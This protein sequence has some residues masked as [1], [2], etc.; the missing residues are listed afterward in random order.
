MAS[1]RV[2]LRASPRRL[3]NDRAFRNPTALLCLRVIVY[4]GQACTVSFKGT[5]GIR[6]GVEVEAESLYEV[7]VEAIARFRQDPWMEQVGNATIDI[8]IGESATTHAVT[9]KQVES[10]LASTSPSPHIASKKIRLK[11]M[12][13][14]G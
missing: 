6:H 4:D 12:L 2:A 5:S 7:A 11:M 14:N 3:P 8:E 13:M 9:L 1:E 10:W